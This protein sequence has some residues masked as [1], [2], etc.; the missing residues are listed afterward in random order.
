MPSTYTYVHGTARMV[1]YTPGGAVAA[2]D[3]IILT[4]SWRIAH[5][6]I[7]AGRPDALAAGG[8]VY[9]GPKATGGGSG[10]ADGA[11]L[12]ALTATGVIQVSATSAKPL[13]FAVGAAADADATALFLH[14]PF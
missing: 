8:A 14:W 7:A 9:R 1:D 4:D 5:N 2:G 6:D 11:K 12:H 10:W 3:A 13:G